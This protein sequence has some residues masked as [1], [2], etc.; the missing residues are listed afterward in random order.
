MGK[1]A[2]L[3]ASHVGVL[4]PPVVP[5]CSHSICTSVWSISS[6]RR[7]RALWPC[8]RCQGL[9]YSLTLGLT[10]CTH[11]ALHTSSPENGCFC[12]CVPGVSPAAGAGLVSARG[13]KVIHEGCMELLGVSGAF[14][15]LFLLLVRH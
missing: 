13:S 2:V 8:P 11:S 4:C 6:H 1:A 10:Y 3:L 15:R 14:R 7:T 12:L 9:L 5:V